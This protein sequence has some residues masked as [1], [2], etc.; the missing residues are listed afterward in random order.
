MP[1]HATHTLLYPVHTD[2]AP[3]RPAQAQGNPVGRALQSFLSFLHEACLLPWA[4]ALCPL[5]RMLA[6][7]SRCHFSSLSFSKHPGGVLCASGLVPGY[8]MP[9]SASRSSKASGSCRNH[10]GHPGLSHQASSTPRRAVTST[11]L[12]LPPGA[13]LSKGRDTQSS[14]WCLVRWGDASV[15]A[16]RGRR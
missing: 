3:A 14:G 6:C 11:Y 9:E 8:L 1:L 15:K 7:L 10:T 5:P 2:R 13:R 12:Q 4:R 16:K